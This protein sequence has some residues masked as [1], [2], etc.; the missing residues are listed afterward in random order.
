MFFIVCLPNGV[1]GLVV[2]IKEGLKIT[3]SSTYLVKAKVN[4]GLD[5]IVQ[6]LLFK[7]GESI[8]RTV[9]V[10]VKRI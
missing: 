1:L 2:Y 6:E 10:Q 5:F 3:T 7:N 9:V 8:L 4:F